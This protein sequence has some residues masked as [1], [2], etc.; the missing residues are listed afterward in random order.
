M[1]MAMAMHGGVPVGTTAWAAISAISILSHR[2]V[3]WRGTVARQGKSG[4]DPGCMMC[5]SAS[6][7]HVLLRR[8]GGVG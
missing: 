3:A 7:I 6:S 5:A 4:R 1:H 8:G 2:R